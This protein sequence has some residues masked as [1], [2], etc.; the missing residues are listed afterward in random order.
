MYNFLSYADLYSNRQAGVLGFVVIIAGL[1]GTIAVGFIM[2][3]TRAYR[4]LLQGIVL[5]AV[6]VFF[7]TM[8]VMIPHQYPALIVCMVALGTTMLPV[9]PVMMENCA[10]IAYPISEELA[11]GI[12]FSGNVFFEVMYC[13]TL[14]IFSFF[15]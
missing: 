8:C 2:K 14:F 10:E 1:L 3:R 9:L 4:T 11:T 5:A 7:V 15:V 6:L 13:C 12:V